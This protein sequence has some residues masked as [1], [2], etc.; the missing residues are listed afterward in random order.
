MGFGKSRLGC[1]PESCPPMFQSSSRP[2]TNFSS[3]PLQATKFIQVFHQES[4]ALC[5][6]ILT[7]YESGAQR[8]VGECRIGADPYDI[9]TKPPV[10]H[11]LETTYLRPGTHVGCHASKVTFTCKS[12]HHEDG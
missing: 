8:A 10:L 11:I 7:E 6:G 4:S 1:L 3:A 12:G 2:D 5:K 9:Y